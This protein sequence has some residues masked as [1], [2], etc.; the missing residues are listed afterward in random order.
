LLLST[1]LLATPG[2][3]HADTWTEVAREFTG[4][5]TWLKAAVRPAIAE[6]GTVAFVGQDGAFNDE[7][8]SRTTS[9]ALTKVTL[10]G[11]SQKAVSSIQ[12]NGGRIAY[13]AKRAASYQGVY[14]MT[15]SG[16]SKATIY[17][18]DTST[19]AKISTN[20]ALSPASTVSF[21]TIVNG[22]GKLLRG[23]ITATA[24]TLTS[25][26]TGSGTFYN[27]TL[28]DV[29]DSGEV[30]IGME[31][32]DPA[33]GLRRAIFR[34]DA[35]GETLATADAAIEKAGVG[36]QPT[37]SI[38]ATG[39]IAFSLPS[40]VTITYWNPP[41]VTT[42]TVVSSVTLKAGVYLA[43]PAPFGTPPTITKITDVDGPWKAF[44]PVEL[45]DDGRV[46][47]AATLDNGT[48]GI[49][50]GSDPVA[51]KIV[52]IGDVRGSIRVSWLSLGG[53]NNSGE[54][55]IATSDFNTTDR[56][57]WRVSGL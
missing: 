40:T 18:V 26:V 44:G 24:A 41:N 4:G 17:E 50:K 52:E 48:A 16:G 42:A 12:V 22:A 2:A 28:L 10:T 6:N 35:A 53:M 13:V 38:N 11:A 7:L 23:P 3:A 30:A 49:Y 19:G 32:A 51:D 33:L 31:Y 9:G 45:D 27:N 57:I 29:N 54:I 39:E 14:R 43:T 5:M 47:F 56:Q 34:F 20:V 8:F 15:T 46:V 21:S 1:V 55:A 36:V 25:L 37:L